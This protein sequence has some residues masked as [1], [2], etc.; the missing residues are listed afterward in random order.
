MSKKNKKRLITLVSLLSLI[1]VVVGGTLAY[2]MTKTD[3]VINTFIPAKAPTPEVIEEFD[4]ETKS[5]V[6]IHIK[7]DGQGACFVRAKVVFTLQDDD[8]NVIAQVPVAGE[9]YTVSM[10]TADWTYHDGYWYYNVPVIP[11]C[12]ADAT[13]SIEP[14]GYTTNLINSCTTLNTEYHLV[15]DILAQTIQ[16]NPTRA[17]QTEW[18]YVPGT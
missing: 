7:N 1:A 15:V 2:L 10:N 11:D 14:D 6:R 4:G 18:G 12:N 5:N 16:A 17:A 9:D 8:G 13:D 3:S